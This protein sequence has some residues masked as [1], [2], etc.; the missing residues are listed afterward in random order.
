MALYCLSLPTPMLW[1]EFKKK[2][3]SFIQETLKIILEQI[4]NSD[5][6]VLEFK[7]DI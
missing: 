6:N 7:V 2:E 4:I 1:F 3:M 5:H